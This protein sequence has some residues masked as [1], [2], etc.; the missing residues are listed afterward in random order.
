VKK[1]PAGDEVVAFVP[2]RV[3]GRCSRCHT[4]RPQVVRAGTG[5]Q[6]AVLH[7][8]EVRC[9]GQHLEASVLE[10]RDGWVRIIRPRGAAPLLVAVHLTPP[11]DT[12][13]RSDVRAVTISTFVGTA[14]SVRRRARRSR[15]AR[16]RRPT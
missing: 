16:R 8:R 4:N 5:D 1:S 6:R 13:G 7:R 14:R 12:H 10:L 3:T 2:G 9:A 11:G 15:R